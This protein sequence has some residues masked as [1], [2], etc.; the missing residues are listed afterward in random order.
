EAM[1]PGFRVKRFVEKPDVETASQ[2]VASG[3]YFW[4]SGMFVFRVSAILAAMAQHCPAILAACETAIS[5]KQTDQDFC[6]PEANAFLACPADSIDY[7]VMEK[8]DRAA[9]VPLN[10][11]WSDVGSWQSLWQI[12]DKTEAGNVTRGDVLLSA[13]SDSYVHADHRLVSVV[14]VD[15]LVVVETADAVMIADKNRSQD[16]KHLVTQLRSCDREE[17]MTHRKVYRP[18]GHY[19]SL[20]QGE[21]FQVKRI[22]VNPGASLSLQMHHHRAE[23]WVVVTGTARVINGDSDLRLNENEST[24]IPVETRHRLENVGDSLLEIIEIQTGSYLGEDD[25]VRFEDNYGRG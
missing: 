13:V 5:A 23:H 19:E 7:A 6:R 20:D 4:N 18:W 15:N 8:T 17:H 1:G 9:M 25:I 3:D 12:M 24:Y 2:Y 10:A 22:C 11:G 14:G 21:R 16:V